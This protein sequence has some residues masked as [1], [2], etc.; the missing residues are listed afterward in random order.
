M[1]K[2]EYLKSRNSNKFSL[3][4]IYNSLLLNP[5]FKVASLKL[6]K[7][8]YRTLLPILPTIGS[9]LVVE[10]KRLNDIKFGVTVLLDKNKREIIAY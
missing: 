5:T 2:D 1:N 6:F 7:E 9:L 4:M 3:E 8:H 10:T